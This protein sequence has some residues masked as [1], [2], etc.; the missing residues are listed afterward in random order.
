ICPQGRTGNEASQAM[1]ISG[2]NHLSQL[3]TCLETAQN[4]L[5]SEE[6]ARETFG[7]LTAAIEQ[8]WEAVCEEA[9]LNEVDKNLLWRRQFLNPYSAEQ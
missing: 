9:E 1:L 4:F 7:N 5:L 3:K 6:E 2:D 8:Y